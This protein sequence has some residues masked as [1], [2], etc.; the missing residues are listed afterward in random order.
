[1]QAVVQAIFKDMQHVEKR[2]ILINKKVQTIAEHHNIIIDEVSEGRI[3]QQT[4]WAGAENT[5]LL[6]KLENLTMYKQVK[7]VVN[8][9]F[10]EGKPNKIVVLDLLQDDS[11]V[12]TMEQIFERVDQQQ[13]EIRQKKEQE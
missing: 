2:E 4:L 9:N 1:M 7:L 8:V 5:E 6:K 3:N 12:K 13:Q 10:Y 11:E